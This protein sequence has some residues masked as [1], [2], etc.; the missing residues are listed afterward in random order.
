MPLSLASAINSPGS[1]APGVISIY[2]IPTI[3]LYSLPIVVSVLGIGTL[4]TVLLLLGIYLLRFV[5]GF[6]AFRASPVYVLETISVSHYVELIRWSLDR[7][8]VE[9]KEVE[10]VGVLGVMLYHRLVPTLHIPG[11]KTSIS[12]SPDI[13]NFLYG[14]HINDSQA[15][16]LKPIANPSDMEFEEKL[17]R[18]AYYF[19]LWAYYYVLV[20]NAE[21]DLLMRVW[22]VRQ[23]FVP[24]WQAALMTLVFPIVRWFVVCV[25][26]IFPVA[27]AFAKSRPA[28]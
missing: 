21:K 13:M 11:L 9:Y 22:G 24:A 15:G 16:F 2:T 3:L 19:R 25:M 26:V 23:P 1:V 28:N 27:S 17:T 14:R 5:L 6:I 18:G 12:N 4:A 8:G 7:L 10:T 20:D